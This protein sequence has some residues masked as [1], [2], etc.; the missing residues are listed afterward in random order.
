MNNKQSKKIKRYVNQDWKYT[1]RKVWEARPW[2]VP[3]FVWVWV[4]K[5]A[6]VSNKKHY[7][8]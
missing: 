5:C 3:K 1:V 7:G 8:N 6:F 2:F 4:M